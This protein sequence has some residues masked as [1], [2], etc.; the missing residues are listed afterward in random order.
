MRRLC[1]VSSLYFR[2]IDVL[3]ARNSGRCVSSGSQASTSK[4][5]ASSP[6]VL[7]PQQVQ[8][9]DSDGFLFLPDLL[10]QAEIKDLV[11]WTGEV[12]KWPET[13]G[14]RTVSGSFHVFVSEMGAKCVF[15]LAR[16]GKMTLNRRVS[17]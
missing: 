9:F 12:E 10:T 6:S 15:M 16:D 13:A 4:A 2:Q 7:T 17:A 1:S 8:Q 5:P 14:E 3:A 11:T